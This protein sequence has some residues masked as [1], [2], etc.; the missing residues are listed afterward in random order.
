[1]ITIGKFISLC[2]FGMLSICVNADN[3]VF[4]NDKSWLGEYGGKWTVVYFPEPA[5]TSDSV[6]KEVDF[7]P[8][9][10][11]FAMSHR[12]VK[13]AMI[14][15]NDFYVCHLGKVSDQSWSVPRLSRL[16]INLKNLRKSHADGWITLTSA[17]HE[18]SAFCLELGYGDEADIF[19]NC[20]QDI[21]I[22]ETTPA[23]GKKIG[24]LSVCDLTHGTINLT[25]DLSS[26]WSLVV[27]WSS[28]NSK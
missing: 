17:D 20:G 5:S 24:S 8:N 18:K 25:G 19:I 3:L 6:V 9:E 28:K 26:K 10:V 14:Y 22:A 23:K 11:S 27:D 12:G 2:I 13:R 16:H 7:K 4:D 1:M 21:V 15:W